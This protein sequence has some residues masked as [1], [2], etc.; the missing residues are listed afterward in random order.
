MFFVGN[1][2]IQMPRME[3]NLSK[4]LRYGVALAAGIIIFAGVFIAV[5]KFY[6]SSGL[7]VG[8]VVIMSIAHAAMGLGF[9]VGFMILLSS[10]KNDQEERRR[11]KVESRFE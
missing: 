5:L 10:R 1:I 7:P 8:F 3:I 4:R 2:I 6:R 9:F 11:E